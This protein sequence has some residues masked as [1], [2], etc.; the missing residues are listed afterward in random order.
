MC[1]PKAFE[2]GQSG[3]VAPELR[4][5]VTEQAQTDTRFIYDCLSLSSYSRNLC[6]ISREPFISV[7]LWRLGLLLSITVLW[8]PG[9]WSNIVNLPI[10]IQT[11]FTH[12]LTVVHSL[13]IHR[14]LW[15]SPCAAASL[16]LLQLNYWRSL[17][18]LQK[19]EVQPAS[20]KANSSFWTG[21]F[22]TDNE[23]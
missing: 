19:E 17:T 3:G 23:L 13:V 22:I 2:F 21:S 1:C 12:L 9:L 5:M 14:F 7:Q 11:V 20:P 16:Y 15:T 8:W 10:L 18:Q 4:N 6:L